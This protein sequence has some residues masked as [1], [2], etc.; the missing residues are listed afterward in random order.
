[1]NF[2]F[3]QKRIMNL[4]KYENQKEMII[5]NNRNCITSNT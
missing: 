2:S 1:M 3:F 4:N 5:E